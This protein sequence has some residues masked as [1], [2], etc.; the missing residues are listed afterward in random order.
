MTIFNPSIPTNNNI[1][2]TIEQFCWTWQQQ[3]F[4]IIYEK[5]G[6]GK[7]I[8][9]LPA[10][11]T[12]SSRT[13]MAKIAH[14]LAPDYQVF[15]LDWLGFG[16]SDRP[17]VNYQ[18]SVY[19]Q[20]L[21]DFVLSNFQQPIT[22]IAAGHGSGYALQLAQNYPQS[23]SKIVLI[24]P[25]WKGPLRVMGLPSKMR[26]LIKNLVRSP[27]IGQFLYY[28][29]TTPAFLRFMYRRHVYIDDT[30]LTPDFITHKR[31]ITQHQGARFAPVAFVTG[32]IDPIED[33]SQILNL[34]KSLSQPILTIIA[35]QSPPYSK[36]EMSAIAELSNVESIE[37]KGTLGIYEEYPEA[38]TTAIRG[39]IGS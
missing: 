4:T 25:T 3:E 7:P 13:E 36:T 2:G 18:P 34:I 39:F 14:S 8:L 22:I 30:K 17:C 35:Q 29:N 28:L 9:L 19:H 11:S 24:A 12:V 20:L 38:V 1:G 27:I 6:Q 16:D 26:K 10:F 5:L 37:L 32:E 15:V 31:Q 23:V 21:T 33:R